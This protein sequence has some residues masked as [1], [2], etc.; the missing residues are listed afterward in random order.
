MP[1]KMSF[2]KERILDCAFD[3]IRKDGLGALSARRIAQE[4][5]CSTRPVYATFVSMA[6]LQEAAIQKA[7]EFALNYFLKAGKDSD[8]PFLNLGLK[9]FQFSQEERSLFTL[10]YME[11]KMGG[12]FENLGRHFGPLLDR[13]KTDP[14]ISGFSEA[15][16]KRLGTNT[17]IYTHGLIALIHAFQ[18]DDAEELIRKLIS[19]MG[20]VLCEWEQHQ[21]GQAEKS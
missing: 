20:L 21:V 11:G 10:L 3:I 5:K 8:S 18:S 4:L 7:R 13:M 12:S 14:R 15:A 1:P 6:A 9:Y 2:T 16:L 17:W 19:Q